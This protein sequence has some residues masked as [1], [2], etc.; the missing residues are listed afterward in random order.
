[1]F[2]SAA[3]HYK[4]CST[5]DSSPQV[6]SI[7][8]AIDVGREV[9]RE[10]P[11][12]PLLVAAPALGR[13]CVFGNL[14][15]TLGR[16][17]EPLRLDRHPSMSRHPVTPADESDL[18]IHLGRQT[19]KRIALFD[20]LKLDL[21]ADAARHALETIVADKPDIVLF[22]LLYER[23]LGSAGRLI[24]GYASGERPLFVV[25]SSGIDMAFAA[26]WSAQGVVSPRRNFLNPGAARPLLV[27]SGS[28]SPVTERQIEWALSRGFAEV[29]LDTPAIATQ[30]GAEAALRSASH[31]AVAH[32][33]ASR[34]VIIHTT[35]GGNDRR[36][37][38]T[39]GVLGSGTTA[40]VLGEALATVVRACV[41]RA[42]VK[43]VLIAGGDTSGYFARALGVE[44]LEMIAP[45]T[46]GAPLC[47]AYAATGAID[48][49]EM[50]FKGGQVGGPDYFDAVANGRADA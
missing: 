2:A 12:V 21:P 48:G 17:P 40:R 18:R 33:S 28:C 29:A 47:R 32:L 10:A 27:A 34:H 50:N 24:D 5:F 7:G 44:A 30:N 1:L 23:Q 35:R 15:A 38:A 46:P 45:M 41:T 16:D 26:Y 20:I 13:Y 37:A 9:F 6:G 31:D 14:F 22:D 8:R 19:D 36:L 43:R 42:N 25:G 4:V 39:T 49:L 3:V 11:F